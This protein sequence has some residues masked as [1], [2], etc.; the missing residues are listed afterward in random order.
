MDI[1]TLE[2]IQMVNSGEHGKF[3]DSVDSVLNARAGAAIQDFKKEVAA[4]MFV[5]DD[6]EEEGDEEQEENDTEET[7]ENA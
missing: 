2:L 5:A 7:D 4:N 3:V 6:E 1:D